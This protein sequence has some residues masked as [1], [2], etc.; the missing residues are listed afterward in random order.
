MKR[1]ADEID[2][3]LGATRE[4]KYFDDIEAEMDVR[5]VEQA[6]P[7]KRAADDQ[8]LL[9]LVHCI[10]GI[11]KV[12]TAPRLYL[13]EDERIGRTLPTNQIHFAPTRCAVVSIQN[14][15]SIPL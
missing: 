6:K 12:G 7:G 10:R 4:D 2:L 9:L 14:L 13:N 1:A 11:A 5:P 8:S 15:V 3:R